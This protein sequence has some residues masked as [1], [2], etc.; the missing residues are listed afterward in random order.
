MF[1]QIIGAR[2]R[3]ASNRRK[4][5][6][7]YRIVGLCSPLP[8]V[9]D[10]QVH[11]KGGTDPQGTKFPQSEMGRFNGHLVHPRSHPAILLELLQKHG[12]LPTR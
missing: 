3:A 10:A 1:R 4:S 11:S 9:A 2:A 5:A 7:R 6:R 8:N 12:E